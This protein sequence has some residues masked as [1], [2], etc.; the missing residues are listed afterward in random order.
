[1]L[2]ILLSSLIV[3]GI[4]ASVLVA[5]ETSPVNPLAKQKRAEQDADTAAVVA[6]TSLTNALESANNVAQLKAAL[7]TWANAELSAKKIKKQK[8]QKEKKP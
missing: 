1:M 7:K 8:E 3:V 5:A 6:L 2:K 4:V